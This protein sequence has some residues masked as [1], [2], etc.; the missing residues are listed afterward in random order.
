VVYAA[1]ESKVIE[2]VPYI[3]QL[4]IPLTVGLVAAFLFRQKKELALVSAAFIV[5]AIPAIVS[6]AL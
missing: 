5:S 3:I 1:E 4:L 2:F 6:L